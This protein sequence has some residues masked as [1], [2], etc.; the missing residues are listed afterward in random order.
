MK[1]AEGERKGTAGGPFPEKKRKVVVSRELIKPTSAEAE[2]WERIYLAYGAQLYA[3]AIKNDGKPARRGGR[4]AGHL[5][6]D[7]AEPASH[8]SGERQPDLQ[9]HLHDS[10]KLYAGSVPEAKPLAGGNRWK[11][12]SL[13]AIHR[14]RSRRWMKLYCRSCGLKRLR[15]MLHKWMKIPPALCAEVLQSLY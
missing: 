12:G 1:Q 10:A 7:L 11:R 6:E 14:A 3:Y 2:K 13:P 4:P 15:P 8:F 9:L 5:F